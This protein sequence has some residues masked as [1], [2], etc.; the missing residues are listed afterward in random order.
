MAIALLAG[1]RAGDASAEPSVTPRETAIEMR[2][3]AGSDARI[4]IEGRFATSTEGPRFAWPGTTVHVR[5]VGT[6]FEVRLRDTPFDDEIKD[7]DRIGVRIDDEPMITIPL[8][9]GISTYRIAARL[10]RR[11][12]DV[13]IVKLTEAE[14]GT[15]TLASIATDGT[16]A[17]AKPASGRRLLAIGDSITAGYGIDGPP[18][19][20]YDARYA[21]AARTWVFRAADALGA[22]RQLIAWSGRGLVWNYDPELERTMPE[23]M[24]R[25]LPADDTS[26][27]EHTTFMPDAI[28]INLGTN[29]VSR[30]EYDRAAFTRN[31]L[32]L[33]E[34]LRESY[35]EVPIVLAYGPLISDDYPR[36]GIGTLRRMKATLEAIVRRR[37]QRGD[38]RITL[39]PLPSVNGLEGAGCDSHPSAATHER[40][41]GLLITALS[42]VW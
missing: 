11:Q 2:P 35:G 4:R 5:F 19:C 10:P 8:R 12:H 22:E 25:T 14:Q 20:H 17:S 23:L 30:P 7:L 40:L 13:R 37:A 38:R 32:A 24:R 31:Y 42:H 34:S 29:D 3:V 15:I 9:E 1:C 27:F 26:T 6:S 33:L 36:I 41:A 21:N 28:V 16:V 39:L 18:G